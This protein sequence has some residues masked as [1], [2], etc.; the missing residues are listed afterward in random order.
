MAGTSQVLNRVSASSGPGTD[1]Q[2]VPRSDCGL[3][4][5]FPLFSLHFPVVF[6]TTL[7]LQDGSEIA[8]HLL[9]S[10]TRHWLRR[11]QRPA[12]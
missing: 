5:L 1:P 6:P 8:Q 12:Q 3:L 9:Q 11:T 7:L 2:P 4:T 10:E